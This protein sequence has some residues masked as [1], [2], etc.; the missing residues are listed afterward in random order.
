MVARDGRSPA[1]PLAPDP[2][3]DLAAALAEDPFF[4]G[5][6]YVE[7]RRP[8]GT[9]VHEPVPLT[10]EEAWHSE[11]GWWVS[12]DS[13]HE[14]WRRYLTEALDAAL[15]ADPTALVLSNVNIRWDH[16]DLRKPTSPDVAV[17]LGV[18][19]RRRWSTFD[20]AAEGARP[21]LALEI[22]SPSSVERD[23]VGKP[24]EYALARV[25]L[26]VTIDTVVSRR[27][28]GPPIL[29]GWR[30]VGGVYQP[31]P[32]D[33]RGRLWLEEMGLWLGIEGERP[34][35][36]DRDDRPLLTYAELEAELRRRRGEGEPG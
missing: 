17:L 2:D 15:A 23:R 31:L 3:P 14:A 4:Y 5:Y 30:L 25:P 18:R 27:R 16:P 29:R 22:V 8:D 33:G 10:A 7:R 24:A 34:R 1:T 11:E 21:A 36:Y 26:Y 9:V 32:L 20:I 12:E 35:L 28:H 19:A 13:E 6:R